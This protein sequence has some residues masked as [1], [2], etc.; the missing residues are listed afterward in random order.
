MFFVELVPVIASRIGVHRCAWDRDLVACFFYSL[1]LRGN[2]ETEEPYCVTFRGEQ[3]HYLE[4]EG[5]VTGRIWEER[6]S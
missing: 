1:Y 6:D 2:T 3:V 4:S 5:H